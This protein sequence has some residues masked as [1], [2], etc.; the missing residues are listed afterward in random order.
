MTSWAEIT[1]TRYCTQIH[2]HS[3]CDINKARMIQK[4]R[5][6]RKS[7]YT[8]VGVCVA[9]SEHTQPSSPQQGREDV[10]EPEVQFILSWEPRVC[11]NRHTANRLLPGCFTGSPGYCRSDSVLP[12]IWNTYTSNIVYST[13]PVYLHCFN[14]FY[15][16]KKWSFSDFCA[17]T[18]LT[19]S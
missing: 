13:L 18:L 9:P 14:W 12:V 5:K 17:H 16:E 4:T 2:K 3:K 6:Y 10:N 19:I 11:C 1:A 7:R 8:C 15:I